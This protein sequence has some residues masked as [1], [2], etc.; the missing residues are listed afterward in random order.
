VTLEPR[1][2]YAS[3]AFRNATSAAP[4]QDGAHW[5]GQPAEPTQARDEYGEGL[6]DPS[7]PAFSAFAT[8]RRGLSFEDHA[9]DWCDWLLARLDRG[10]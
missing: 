3:C 5:A 4:Q 8:L 9:I 6:E 10:G 2:D 1:G 7:T